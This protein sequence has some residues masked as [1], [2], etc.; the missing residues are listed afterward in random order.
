MSKEKITMRDLERIQET[1]VDKLTEDELVFG[2]L[3]DPSPENRGYF[4][5]ALLRLFPSS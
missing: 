4:A 3:N 5:Q 2:M 1:R